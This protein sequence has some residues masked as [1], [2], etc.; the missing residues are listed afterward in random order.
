[1]L[2]GKFTFQPKYRFPCGYPKEYYRR[3]VLQLHFFANSLNVSK[4][5]YFFLNT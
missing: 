5:I 4:L 2:F 3:A 1:M